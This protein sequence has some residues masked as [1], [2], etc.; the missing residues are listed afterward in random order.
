MRPHRQQL[1]TILTSE[2]TREG[3]RTQNIRNRGRKERRHA[4]K[5]LRR[6]CPT[7][8][9]ALAAINWVGRCLGAGAIPSGS[10]R[11]ASDRAG[12]AFGGCRATRRPG[13]RSQRSVRAGW[14]ASGSRAGPPYAAPGPPRPLRRRQPIA[15]GPGSRRCTFGPMKNES[16]GR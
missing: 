11:S 5:L 12:P 1:V 8:C 6:L 9:S 7:R 15:A 4:A 16:R 13:C 2:Q 14:R 10:C 3:E